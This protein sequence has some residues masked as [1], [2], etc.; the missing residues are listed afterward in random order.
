MSL[1]AEK[2][3]RDLDEARAGL[4]SS[5]AA[6]S[7]AAWRTGA[8]LMDLDLAKT[9]ETVSDGLIEESSSNV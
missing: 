5:N 4:A 6:Y 7:I 1:A 2:A 9:V 3:A 8:A